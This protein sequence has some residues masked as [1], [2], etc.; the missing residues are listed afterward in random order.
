M[1]GRSGLECAFAEADY[2]AGLD[3]GSAELAVFRRDAG[4]SLAQARVRR[5]ADAGKRRDFAEGL[6][7]LAGARAVSDDAELR[8]EA[9]RVQP[10]LVKGAVDEAEALR[11]GAQY[12]RGLRSS[13]LPPRPTGRCDRGSRR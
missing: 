1:R 5:A 4:R 8:A 6:Q 3:G 9:Q 12:P 10:L 11:R 2:A 7:L 13:A